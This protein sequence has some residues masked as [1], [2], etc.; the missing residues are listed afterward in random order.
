[1]K[2]VSKLFGGSHVLHVTSVDEK[3]DILEHI[4][5]HTTLR[6]PEKNRT[7]KLLSNNNIDVLKK[8]CSSPVCK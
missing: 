4:Y 5:E 3:K 1:M 2:T 8:V 7:M 6:L